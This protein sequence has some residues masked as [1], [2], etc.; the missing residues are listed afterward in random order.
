MT[1]EKG[2]SK[3][4][5]GVLLFLSLTANVFLGGVV[6]GKHYFGGTMNGQKIVRLIKTFGGLSAESQQKAIASVEKDWPAVREQFKA[7][8]EKR[9]AVK[10]ILVQKEY[11]EEELDKA[12]DAVRAQVDLLMQAGQV[13]G[14]NALG[15]I[16][17]E[18]RIK[19]I[20]KLPRPPAE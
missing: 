5:L 3:K 12:M 20:E 1:T 19:L 10:K 2:V 9:D 15:T 14:K 4:C 16:T 11:S 8:R 13:L 18:E 17:P 6:V 7:V